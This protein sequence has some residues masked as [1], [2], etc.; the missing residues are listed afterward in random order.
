MVN[1]LLR[2]ATEAHLP[3]LPSEQ[4]QRGIDS[5]AL[6]LP[7][8]TPDWLSDS[9]AFCTC[10]VGTGLRPLSMCSASPFGRFCDMSKTIGRDTVVR[11]CPMHVFLRKRK[12]CGV[13]SSFRVCRGVS[14]HSVHES[15]LDPK[16]AGGGG[17]GFISLGAKPMVHVH[18]H[19]HRDWYQGAPLQT[20]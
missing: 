8:F 1:T 5:H 15:G 4:P 9:T 17:R 6:L 7:S 11:Y 16:Q 20:G 14:P 3:Q 13:N 2:R 19:Q 18:L 10:T 12:F